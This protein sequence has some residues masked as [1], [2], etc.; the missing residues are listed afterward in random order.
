MIPLIFHDGRPGS[1]TDHPID[2]PKIIATISQFDLNVSLIDRRAQVYRI[3][4]IWGKTGIDDDPA[5]IVP[6]V[7]MVVPEVNRV[8]IQVAMF[9]FR[10]P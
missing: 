4:I 8:S 2:R 1:W 6:P 10:D 9:T 7:T 3:L 5:P